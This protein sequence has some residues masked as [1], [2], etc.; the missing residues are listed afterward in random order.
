M[1][2]DQHSSNALPWR[3][4]AT[5][6]EAALV[7]VPRPPDGVWTA[8]VLAEIDDRTAIVALP[9]CHWTDG[10]LVDLLAVAERVRAS[11]A[12]LVLDLTQ[13]LGALPFDVAEVDPDFIYCAGYKWLLG[14]YSFGF[15]YVAP[16][17]HDGV[18]LE[19]SSLAR[20]VRPEVQQLSPRDVGFPLEARR[21][22]V[23]ESANF[24][25]LPMACAALR[26]VLD[27]GVAEIQASLSALT[28]EIADRTGAMGLK[29]ADRQHRAGHFLG[30]RFPGGPPPDLVD[31]LAENKVY[32]SIRG[33]SMRVTPHLFN[34]RGDI[35]R[36][37]QALEAVV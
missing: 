4:L 14:P 32:V 21:F 2:Q 30:V 37:F 1:L 7:T 3:D 26:Q 9:N 29:V 24:A 19:H 16:R 11:G 13:S 33:D 8:D 35:D 23:G 12:A 5:E 17:R 36:M 25:L 10:T 22:D 6:R 20:I 31:R 28:N 18:P 34:D 27:W 15:M